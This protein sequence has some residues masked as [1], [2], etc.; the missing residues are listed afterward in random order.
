VLAGLAVLCS[1]RTR[2]SAIALIGFDH[3]ASAPAAQ[4]TKLFGVGLVVIG[5]LQ[6]LGTLALGLSITDPAA[7]VPRTLFALAAE[8]LL[9]AVATRVAP[10]RA[11]AA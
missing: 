4:V 5:A 8:G 10:N 6:A 1:E 2:R 3:P 9:L 11:P 7:V